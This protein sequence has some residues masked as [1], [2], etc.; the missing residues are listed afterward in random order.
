[1]S[2]SIATATSPSTLSPLVQLMPWQLVSVGNDGTPRTGSPLAPRVFTS[3]WR[4]VSRGTAVICGPPKVPLL[5]PVSRPLHLRDAFTA[6]PMIL[7]MSINFSNPSPSSLSASSSLYQS[8]ENLS[9]AMIFRNFPRQ[10]L[11][12]VA[13]TLCVPY[14]LVDCWRK[15]PH[16]QAF[17]RPRHHLPPPQRTRLPHQSLVTL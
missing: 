3:H 5:Q 17:Q 12:M 9:A 14:P 8:N 10:S 15:H 6:S 13:V 2:I 11:G 16:F 1:M 4:M 7:A